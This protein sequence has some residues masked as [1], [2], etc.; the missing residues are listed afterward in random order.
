MGGSGG[1]LGWIEKS[2]A[3]RIAAILAVVITLYAAAA[4][5][6]NKHAD[7]VSWLKGWRVI[8]PP[9]DVLVAAGAILGFI[10]LVALERRVYSHGWKSLL[11]PW[12][13]RPWFDRFMAGKTEPIILG[14]LTGTSASDEPGAAAAEPPA[15]L[16]HKTYSGGREIETFTPERLCEMRRTPGLT[17]LQTDG[18]LAKY[19]GKWMQ[20][21][22][23]AEQIRPLGQYEV[24]VTPNMKLGSDP[25]RLYF[26]KER[27]GER[28]S[29]LHRG[30]RVD[31][32]GQLQIVLDDQVG[33]GNCEFI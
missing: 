21:A 12:R 18:L 7:A 10:A 22:I 23:I 8:A 4:G 6:L 25:V 1:I 11:P 26:N 20:A 5:W 29:T 28:L 9:H 13:E 3:Y 16:V 19:M 31:A 14:G 2:P 32:I 15:R 30:S 24:T 27:W 33:L 17:E